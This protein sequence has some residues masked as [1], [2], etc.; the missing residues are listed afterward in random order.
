[1]KILTAILFIAVIMMPSP[2]ILL[3]GGDVTIEDPWIPAAPPNAP[4]LAAF[5]TIRNN[6]PGPVTIKSVSGDLFRKIEIHR[7][8]M[9]EGMMKMVRQDGLTIQPGESIELAPGGYHFMLKGPS[10]VPLAGE[11]V[12]LRISFS[13]GTMKS[14][15]IPVVKSYTRR[16]HG[17]QR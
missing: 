11:E 2:G 7:T 1:M 9:H 14:V 8:E 3:A 10:R 12:T 16:L 13:D 17:M 6:S 4:V 5:M 15:T